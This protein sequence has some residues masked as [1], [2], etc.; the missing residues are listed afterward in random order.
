MITIGKQPFGDG[1]QNAA[2]WCRMSTLRIVLKASQQS[3]TAILG[4]FSLH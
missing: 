4:R 2:Q 3:N 1:N